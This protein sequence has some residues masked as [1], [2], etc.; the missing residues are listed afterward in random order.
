VKFILLG[1]LLCLSAQAA[2][3]L[4]QGA[5]APNRF[6]RAQQSLTGCMDEQ[7][8]QYVLLNGQMLKIARL[9]S[10]GSDNEVFAKHLGR[11]VEVRGVQSSGQ[12]SPFKVTSI[13]QVSGN[14]GQAK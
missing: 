11:K 2:G 13:Q 14:C 1:I 9:R 6:S 10:A 3:K 7:D 12:N 5:P 8:G 4:T